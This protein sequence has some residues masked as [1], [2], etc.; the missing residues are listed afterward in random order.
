VVTV[1]PDEQRRPAEGAATKADTTHQQP[2]FNADGDYG[3]A[4][5]PQHA[6]MLRASGIS[7]A[8]ARRRGYVTVDTKKRLADLGITAAGRNV[9]GLLIPL[10][11]ADGSVWG[12]QYRPDKPRL[13]G[14]G[15]PVKYETP[16]GQ[17]NG[18]DVPPGVGRLLD[19]PT[20]PLVLT[21]GTKKADSAAQRGLACVALPGVWSWRGS[22]GHG[23]KTAIPDWHDIA[24]NGRRVPLAFDSDVTVKRSVRAAL[25]E[26]ASY[27]RTKDARP[28]YAHLPDDGDGKCGLD[29]FLVVH[30]VDEL[31]ALVKPDPPERPS[32]SSY[33][34]ATG[35][36][37]HTPPVE[38]PKLAENKDILRDM[39]VCTEVCMGLV[40]EDK[41][42]KLVYLMF[43][44]RLLR[45]PVNGVVKGLS[46][47][48]KSFTI[49]CVARLMPPEAFYVMTSMSQHALIY[50]GEDMR[51]RT[52]VLFEATALRE[53]R[54][55]TED[56]ITA[57]IVRSLLSEGRIEYPTVTKGKDGKFVTTKIVKEGPTNL[58][59]STTAVSLH[60]ENE[61][62]MLSL[63]SDDSREQTRRVLRAIAADRKRRDADLTEWH[64]YQR[65]LAAANHD[66]DVPY[67]ACLAEQIP[68][69]AVRLRRDFTAVQQLIK[70]HA[71]MHQLSRET[72]PHG[73]I[74]A[75]LDDYAAVRYL[76]N[77]LVAEAIGATVPATVR[78][79]VDVVRELNEADRNG[80]KVA[81]IAAL[82]KVERSAAH[83]RLASAADHGYVVNVE[84]KRGKPARYVLGDPMPGTIAVLPDP[85]AVCVAHPCAHLPAH[86][87]AQQTRCLCTGVCS[88]ARTAEGIERATPDA[89]AQTAAAPETRYV[90]RDGCTVADDS[91]GVENKPP[92]RVV[93]YWSDNDQPLPEPPD[94]D[95]GA[96]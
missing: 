21:E 52:V 72:D 51:H 45:E 30:S 26:L 70:A 42:A 35:A 75:D 82:L 79:T 57:Y 64:V 9:P 56:N 43:T 33:P 84:D 94:D 89:T 15:K 14:N 85:E 7:P 93:L 96:A 20:V 68:D 16:V 71:V 69:D 10:L 63:P 12:Y 86:P 23:G 62:R 19:D 32:A 91:Q 17:R 47:S 41:T 73:R 49:E 66:V 92:H 53:S 90:P 65:W 58:I 55:K 8:W 37:L 78:E 24:L 88:C 81:T 76:V 29:D 61:T 36:H 5:F 77:D 31:W 80:A 40:G 46:S 54:E 28:E 4:I 67:A 22:N 34:S 18:I 25:D 38:P 87:A 48:G 83:R 13:N 59:T 27:L 3:L 39:V 6:A 1:A 44:S 74:V 95:W 60:P 2:E 50:L 11:R